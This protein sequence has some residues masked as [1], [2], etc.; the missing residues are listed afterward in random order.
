M[1]LKS[2]RQAQRN[3]PREVIFATLPETILLTEYA[4]QKAFFINELVRQQ[5]QRSFEWYGYTL[6]AKSRPEVI[7]DIGLPANDQNL[8]QYVSLTPEQIPG[9]FAAGP[10]NQRLDPFPWGSETAAVFRDR[11]GQPRHGPGFCLR[12]TAVALGQSRDNY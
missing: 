12:P 2:L 10:H 11:R 4:R 8:E 6:G 3:P 9:L 7:L 5:H 1:R